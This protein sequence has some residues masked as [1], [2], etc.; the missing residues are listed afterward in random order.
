MRHP[1]ARRLETLDVR[2]LEVSQG[3]TI[4]IYEEIMCHTNVR[5]R[6]SSAV[7]EAFKSLLSA[8]PAARPYDRQSWGQ[9]ATTARFL[10]LLNDS[11]WPC[12]K[13]SADPRA[14]D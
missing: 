5:N 3:E 4:A 8:T 11:Y 14:Q 2:K 7:I 9:S 12:E 1:L 13:P 6:T 10:S